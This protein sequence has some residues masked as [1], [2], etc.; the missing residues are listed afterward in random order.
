MVHHEKPSAF[1]TA[2][3]APAIAVAWETVAP[4]EALAL[5]QVTATGLSS[6]EAAAR[7]ERFGPNVL[8]GSKRRSALGRLLDQCNN[9]LVY[10]LL[11]A[12]AVTL[13]IGHWLD[14]A[15]II[16]VVLGNAL[17]GFLQESKAEGALAAVHRML[18]QT[19]A[20]LRNG[21][22]L[23]LP[24]ADLVPGDVVL[25]QSGDRVPAD[26]RL[27]E[28]RGLLIDE[29]IL[30]GESVPVAKHPAAVAAGH[31]LGD[32]TCMA[33]SGTMVLAGQATAVVVA[34]GQ[35]SQLG[36]V[37]TLVA[38]VE[39]PT[40]PLLRRLS[41][42]GRKLS[43]GILLFAAAVFGIGLFT[44]TTTP[45]ELFLAAVGLAVAAIPEG[46]PAIVSIILAIGVRRMAARGA[47]VRRTA[48]VES[49]GSVTVICTDKTGTLTRNELVAR[50][51]VTAD[52]SYEVSGD[53]YRPSGTVHNQ[54]GQAVD[55]SEDQTLRE[56]LAAAVLCN[57][58]EIVERDGSWAA[59]GDPI[60]GA[61]LALAAKSG[62]TASSIRHA[63]PRLDL[64]PFESEH[65]YMAT[66]NGSPHA[67]L[68]SVKGAPERLIELCAFERARCGDQPIDRR[69]WQER[70]ELLASGGMRV[71]A[72]AAARSSQPAV[73][74]GEHLPPTLS[75]LGLV[76]FIDPP[77]PEAILAVSACRRAGIAV[78][79]ATGDH[80]ATALAIS[81]EIGLD[82]TGGVL[83]G[84]DLS[85]LSGEALAEAAMRVNV[86]ARV[87]PSHKL[88]LVEALQRAGHSVAMTG[89][90]VNDA[91]ALR[92]ADIG[93]AMGQ[94][95][96]DA[97]REAAQMVLVD[98]NFATI[99]AAVEQ[100]RVISDN[101]RKTLA[102]VLP[103]NAGEALILVT[104][105]LTGMPLPIT[106]LQILWINFATAVTL[107]FALAFDPAERDVMLRRPAKHRARLLDRAMVIRIL[108][109]SA[110]I[111][112]AAMTLFHLA[113][114]A[115]APVA[116]ARAVAVNTVVASEIAYL[117]TIGAIW[118][119]DP[120]GIRRTNLMVP[121]TIVAAIIGQLVLTQWRPAADLFG[122]APLDVTMWAWV[123]CAGAVAFVL[124]RLVEIAFRHA[125]ARNERGGMGVGAECRS[126]AR[127][128][129]CDGHDL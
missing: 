75:L 59:E 97:A 106:A 84:A 41:S 16:A 83:T 26:V 81:G 68:V 4:R 15:V 113:L 44:G 19:A 51:V 88:K 127:Q 108:I 121:T 80:A 122:L 47:L 42:V 61:L 5:L 24:A 92:R 91:P 119:R 125:A 23:A 71:L 65:R 25:L 60:E 95:G 13:A 111:A 90:G 36:R 74:T 11:A 129:G 114:A 128:G 115:E 22:R 27:L 86:F 50:T 118:R 94:K 112:A 124:A 99:A 28:S 107:S 104:A 100:G 123:V 7:Q 14:S 33:F 40:T 1:A 96:S 98:D 78:K 48:A 76:G 3:Q 69:R 45:D 64:V 10:T 117:L 109:I 46:L 77:R 9:V 37:G 34:T 58:A 32:R 67:T 120:A 89:D 39:Q 66:A 101:L 56:L 126:M 52:G 70:A 105:I 87:D 57:D 53:G 82:T 18:A 35:E 116:V 49:L 73:L 2:E 8:P 72:I 38:S 20:V 30:T 31:S 12:V 29:A 43:F 79:M 21:R 102:F 110:L 63:H 85:K 62:L 103:T 17:I 6:A 55:I 54:R 93:V